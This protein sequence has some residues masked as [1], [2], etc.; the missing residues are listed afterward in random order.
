MSVER[1]FAFVVL[2]LCLTTGFALSQEVTDFVQPERSSVLEKNSDYA[3]VRRSLAHKTRGQ[4]ATSENW[5][6]AVAHP[7]A[8][9]ESAKILSA[10]GTA[11]DAWIVAQTVLGLVEPQSS[12][13]GGGGFLVWWDAD[14]KKITTIDARETAPAAA[15]P[16][17]FQHADGTSFGFFDAVVGGRSVGVPGIPA[18]LEKAHEKWGSMQWSELLE[19]AATMARNGFIVSPRLSSSI[20]RDATRL[21][22]STSTAAYFFPD[23]GTVQPGD[24]LT[25]PSYASTLDILAIGGSEAFYTGEV[26]RAVVEIVQNHKNPG[27]L[28]HSDL[29]AYRVD[30]KP[31]VCVRYRGY[32]V[33]GMGPPSSGAIAVGQILKLLE[34]YDLST[35]GSHSPQSWRLIAD[36]SRLAFADRGKY[37]ADTEFVPVPT[38]GLLDPE[39]LRRRSEL[40]SSKRALE[41]ALPGV[42]AGAQTQLL[43]GNA[44]ELPS[45]THMTIQDRYGNVLSMTSTIENGFGS[46]LMSGGFLLNNELTDFSFRD[47]KDGR[48]VANRVQGGK[49][50]RSSMAPTIILKDGLP[51]L[52]LGSP[53]GSR[54]IPYVAQAVI[55]FV[56][57]KMSPQE[58][59]AM[60]HIVNRF[61]TLEI[62]RGTTAA[63]L[64]P[65]LEALGY[66]V[67]LGGLNSG[68]HIIEIRDGRL[69]GGADPRREG[70]V[71]GG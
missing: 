24:L 7:L 67:K 51:V 26:G 56:D 31:A 27:L 61:G 68:L 46:R 60:P 23:G 19:P 33:C 38:K 58:I 20:E 40:L 6:V 57:W 41:I 39:Y 63:W 16:Q 37:V 32:D 13:L 10:G 14:R 35:T 1:I 54:I 49:K 62:E 69:I 4:S 8:A 43:Q 50:P 28:S 36:A 22:N 29:A 52:A 59:A 44:I 53:G 34:P 11:A 47:Q 9:I 17:L 5:M 3:I 71:I 48:Q 15:T 64:A 65:S 45:T 18:L 12:G 25:N 42:P 30:E 21:Q 70:V 2:V 66:D 55:A